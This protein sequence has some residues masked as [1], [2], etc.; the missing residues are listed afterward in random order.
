[1]KTVFSK[2]CKPQ[3]P[4]ASSCSER[5][6]D[7]LPLYIDVSQGKVSVTDH[8]D[9]ERILH[10][11]EER[12]LEQ[13]G[14]RDSALM[15]LRVL[16]TLA[17]M[18]YGVSVRTAPELTEEN[19]N[20][21][22]QAQSHFILALDALSEG[23]LAAALESARKGYEAYSAQFN[24]RD[25]ILL[26]F[27]KELYARE[28]S[29]RVV[30]VRGFRHSP[31]AEI[32]KREFGDRVAARELYPLGKQPAVDHLGE[33][34]QVEWEKKH[35]A[36]APDSDEQKVRISL[37]RFLV[38]QGL[39]RAFDPARGTTVKGPLV[40]IAD[41]LN[42]KEIESMSR[43]LSCN[44]REQIDEV[45]SAQ[46]GVRKKIAQ[47]IE[48]LTEKMELA[49]DQDKADEIRKKI[50]QAPEER[51]KELQKLE[52][53]LARV[54]AGGLLSWLRK[55]GKIRNSEL[56]SFLWPRNSSRCLKRLSLKE[57]RTEELG[58]FSALHAL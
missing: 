56:G 41:R 6:G 58:T 23:D 49:A 54:M 5:L 13:K 15:K 45:R 14:D 24:R 21:Y 33:L 29:A 25:Q 46:A 28:P 52:D 1:M 7:D 32:F 39:Q 50:E 38:E 27:L 36:T 57:I 44:I 35:A 4:A 10:Q 43:W 51:A 19:E 26:D 30:L 8:Q 42:Y 31:F 2:R 55:N 40:E 47:R 22:G 11:L 37:L 17:K 16:F 20:L 3:A 53:R 9:S 18:N 48:R 12:Q 34:V